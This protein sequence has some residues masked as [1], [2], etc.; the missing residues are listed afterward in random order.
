M[1]F[2][3]HDSWMSDT[4][5]TFRSFELPR[6]E[7]VE[8]KCTGHPDTLADGI[9]ESI[10]R[11]LCR[12]YMEEFGEIMHHNVDKVLIIGGRAEPRF[13]GGR[14]VEPPAIVVGGRATSVRS[15]MS[16]VVRDAAS[17]YLK[18][19]VRH[20]DGFV[21]EPRTREGSPELRSLIGKGANDTSIGSGFAPLRPLESMVLE[22]DSMIEGMKGV[23]EDRKIMAVRFDDRVKVVVAAA[24]ISRYIFSMDD[25]IEM[26][27]RIRETIQSVYDAE[28]Y[29]NAADH[30]SS[31]F[32]TVTGTSAEMGDDGATGRGNR[33]NGLITPMRPMTMEAVAGKNPVNHV[34]KIYNVIAQRAAEEISRL[35]GVQEVYVT[36]VSRIGSPLDQPLMKALSIA[37]PEG[38]GYEAESI[39]DD[40]LGRAD[41]LVD[42]FVSGRI[43]IF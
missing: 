9:S 4:L 19:A 12:I 15:S 35:D 3:E 39:L 11:E 31:I 29:V 34:G 17:T 2:R 6:F 32:L 40:W 23:G 20:L 38:A 27:S 42:E 33:A 5:I 24:A 8:R 13:G 43:R 21:V 18:R 41:R 28:V 30:D 14:I 7:V 37:G 25:Y 26:K 36:L 22:I 10:S 1:N 16:E